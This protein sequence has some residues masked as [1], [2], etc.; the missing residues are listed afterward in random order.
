MTSVSRAPVQRE[1]RSGVTLHAD[2]AAAMALVARGDERAL[3]RQ[4]DA[5]RAWLK[6]IASEPGHIG[7]DWRA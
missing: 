7:L 6:R 5:H 3:G 2:D 1:G 4:Y